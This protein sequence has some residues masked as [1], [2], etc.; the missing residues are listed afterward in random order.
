MA[1][2]SMASGSRQIFEDTLRAYGLNGEDDLNIV[3]RGGGGAGAKPVRD[4]QA[5]GFIATTAPPTSSISETAQALPIRLLPV[6]DEAFKKMKAKN[7]GYGR[8]VIPAGIYKGIDK[9]VPTV[10]DD[11]VLIANRDLPDEYAYW[12]VRTIAENLKDIRLIHRALKNLTVKKMAQVQ[13][14]KIHPGAVKYYKEV[15]VLK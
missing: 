15:G 13:A 6:S 7:P 3:F 1:S 14:L 9:D 12:I 8:G 4:R 2:Q 5:I 10:S 11:T